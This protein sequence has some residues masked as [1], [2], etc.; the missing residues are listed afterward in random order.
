IRGRSP[1]V[2]HREK[3]A[4]FLYGRANR[5][6]LRSHEVSTFFAAPI[7]TNV[8]R[9]S[10]ALAGHP[11]DGFGLVRPVTCSGYRGTEL[12]IFFFLACPGRAVAYSG[13]CSGGRGGISA[14]ADV[15]VQP[16]AR[17]LVE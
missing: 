6:Y 17:R 7:V 5:S 1:L 16:A 2:P 14:E 9:M 4:P 12:R 10:I 3:R 13:N 8:P 11:H 15:G